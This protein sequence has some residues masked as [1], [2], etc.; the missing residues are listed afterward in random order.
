MA[1][2]GRGHRLSALCLALPLLPTANPSSTLALQP[3][4]PLMSLPHCPEFPVTTVTNEHI[5]HNTSL[6]SM[7]WGSSGCILPGA[8]HLCQ[9]LEAAACLAL[10]SILQ[11]SSMVFASLAAFLV[12]P[13]AHIC[14]DAH[15]PWQVPLCFFILRRDLLRSAPAS[16]M[17][18]G[19]SLSCLSSDPAPC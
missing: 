16:H 2:Q 17:G 12:C 1:G 8:P 11:T 15:L 14:S 3:M 9:L 19:S 7:F 13:H 5:A 4:G 18:P 10:S 6:I